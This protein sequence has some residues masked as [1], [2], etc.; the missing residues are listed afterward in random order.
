MSKFEFV[1]YPSGDNENFCWDVDKETYIRIKTEKYKSQGKT[2]SEI[3]QEIQDLMKW[4]KAVFH[5]GMFMI[6]PNDVIIKE[7]KVKQ[8]IKIECDT[9]EE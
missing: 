2:E 4:D 8:K 1:G 9:I 6:Y 7:D 5:E 3:K